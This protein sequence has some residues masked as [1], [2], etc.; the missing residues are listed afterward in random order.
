MSE[1]FEMGD[2]AKR[3]GARWHRPIP[4]F[5]PSLFACKGLVSVFLENFVAYIY[6]RIVERVDE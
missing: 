6:G 3:G 5:K 1:R 2:E 4:P